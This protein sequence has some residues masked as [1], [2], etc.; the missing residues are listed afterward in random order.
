MPIEIPSHI[1]TNVKIVDN[2]ISPCDF[3]D[4]L[5]GFAPQ[6]RLVLPGYAYTMEY[7]SH[8]VNVAVSFVDGSKTDAIVTRVYHG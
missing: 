8:R 5:T 3:L 1:S 7:R 6:F 4:W 2:K